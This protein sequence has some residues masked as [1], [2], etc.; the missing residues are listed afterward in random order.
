MDQLFSILANEFKTAEIPDVETLKQKIESAPIKPKPVVE[1]MMYSWDWKEFV[2]PRLNPLENH[3]LFNSFLLKKENGEVRF[4]YKRLPQS[5]EYGPLQGIKLIK[6]REG[7]HPVKAAEFR[8]E[9]LKLDKLMRGLQ[10][11]F[12]TMELERRMTVVTRWEALKKTLESLPAK[13]ERLEKMDLTKLPTYTEVD[14]DQVQEMLDADDVRHI[15]GEF[16]EEMVEE[17]NLEDEIC[18]NMDVCVYTVQKRK[19]PWVGRVAGLKN[20]DSF[21]VHWYEKDQNSKA[22]RYIAMKSDDGSPYTSEL[23]L[24]SVMLWSFTESRTDDSFVIT[25]VWMEC[26]KQEYTK[27]DES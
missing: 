17:G 9:S 21:L 1:S 18:V 22:G 6:S 4:R 23:D 25:P 15:R 19:R 2:E 3:S 13:L 7:L 5:S 27:M 24:S 26:L 12:R 20:R 10:P 11:Y 14:S 8:I 16:F